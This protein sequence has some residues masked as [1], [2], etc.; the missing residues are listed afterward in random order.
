MWS[1]IVTSFTGIDLADIGRNNF[2]NT[3]AQWIDPQGTGTRISDVFHEG[4]FSVLLRKTRT[5]RSRGLR[6]SRIPTHRAKP[7]MEP[8][9]GISSGS[10]EPVKRA[11][12]LFSG[13][14]HGKLTLAKLSELG[15][16]RD[17]R[18]AS[19]LVPF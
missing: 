17:E 18:L 11:S 1:Q 10:M 14:Q 9:P 5:L 19:I 12:T 16:L 3:Q 6:E 7:R 4:R 13:R 8:L 2:G 15:Q